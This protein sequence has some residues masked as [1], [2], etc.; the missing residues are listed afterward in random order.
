MFAACVLQKASSV[1]FYLVYT[2]CRRLGTLHAITISACSVLNTYILHVMGVLP[3]ARPS[4]RIRRWAGGP[5][6]PTKEAPI[7]HRLLPT[8]LHPAPLSD[9]AQFFADFDPTVDQDLEIP[10]HMDLR[11][12]SAPW[13]DILDDDISCHSDLDSEPSSSL[14]SED[15]TVQTYYSRKDLRLHITTQPRYQQYLPLRPCRTKLIHG[16]APH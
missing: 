11:L 2:P 8:P 14:D 6:R 9:L 13:D 5:T 3:R 16:C 4:H 10:Q 12:R 1:M 15:D 7:Q